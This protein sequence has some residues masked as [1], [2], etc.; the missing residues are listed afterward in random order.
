MHVFVYDCSFP[1]R[2]RIQ[3]IK[4]IRISTNRTTTTESIITQYVLELLQI[5]NYAFKISKYNLNDR[6]FFQLYPLSD[7]F[8]LILF[9]DPRIIRFL[10]LK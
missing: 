6:Q 9:L 5:V 7:T 2:K 3:K 1:L 8:L 4:E 10:I